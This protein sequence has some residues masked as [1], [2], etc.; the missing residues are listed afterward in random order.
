MK[1]IL[2]D[3]GPFIALFDQDDKYHNSVIQFL[4]QFSGNLITT[5]PVITEVA[6]LLS[7]N[8]NVQ[9]DFLEWLKREAV[10]LVNLENEHLDRIIQLSRKYSDVPMDLADSSL[11]VIAELTGIKDIISIDADYYIYRTKSKKALNN[12]L[13]DF[14]KAKQ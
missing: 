1:N 2:V 4:K 10:T 5:W 8:V 14:I 11:I 9:I 13:L 6:H 7:F 12:L 3:A